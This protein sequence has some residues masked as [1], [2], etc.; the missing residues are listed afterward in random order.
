MK[1]VDVTSEE[2]G[3][4]L[5]VL[6]PWGY[7]DIRRA[8]EICKIC[9]MPIKEIVEFLILYVEETKMD[10]KDIEIV[11][12][13]YMVS[14]SEVIEI[15]EKY[16]DI[17]EYVKI[18]SDR[19]KTHFFIEKSKEQEFKRKLNELPKNVKKELKKNKKAIFMFDELG[20][21]LSKVGGK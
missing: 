5:M 11:A 7:L 9:G 2:V 3:N 15:T 8:L 4:F 21:D 18:D 19:L 12:L 14:F 13:I 17:N 1:K 6:D 16:F 20:I 10:I